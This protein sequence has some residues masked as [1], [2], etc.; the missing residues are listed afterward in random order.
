MEENKDNEALKAYAEREAA[1]LIEEYGGWDAKEL[2]IAT[3]YTGTQAILSE[4]I[5]AQPLVEALEELIRVC[6]VGKPTEFVRLIGQ[7][8]ER[9]IAALRTYTDSH[10]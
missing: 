6:A 1:R 10:K 5:K 4:A 3:H 7:A 2:K 8:N 9:A